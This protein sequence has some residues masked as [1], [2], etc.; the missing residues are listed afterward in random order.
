MRIVAVRMCIPLVTRQIIDAIVDIQA[1]DRGDTSVNAR[2]VGA[3][4]GFTAAFLIMMAACNVL[5]AHSVRIADL[6]GCK[7]R[8]AV[9]L[10]Y[11]TCTGPSKPVAA[12]WKIVD[13]ISRKSLRLTAK[14]R[15]RFNDGK[16][17]SFITA[18]AGYAVSRRGAKSGI[19]NAAH[20]AR[21]WPSSNCTCSSCVH[22]SSSS[23]SLW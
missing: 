10:T 1:R 11:F 5:A 14:A 9:S 13:M 21:K 4:M 23:V 7:T 22:P 17:D 20:L 18:D 15:Q 12:D 16:I 6:T 8:A 3:L 2:S 19:L